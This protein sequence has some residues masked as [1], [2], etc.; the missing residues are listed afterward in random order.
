MLFVAEPADAFERL[1]GTEE[2]R[3]SAD[4]PMRCCIVETDGAPVVIAGR[5][6][7]ASARK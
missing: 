3:E 5:L 6:E 7:S 4:I 1:F 2:L